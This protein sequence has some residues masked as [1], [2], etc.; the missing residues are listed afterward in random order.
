MSR[1]L[2]CKKR[3]KNSKNTFLSFLRF[4]S[5]SPARMSTIPSQQR[6]WSL[7]AGLAVSAGVYVAA[8]V[9]D[10]PSGKSVGSRVDAFRRRWLFDDRFLSQ[11]ESS[12]LSR[13][14]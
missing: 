6:A 12:F 2:D 4:H 14:L 7:L 9:R 13:S 10:V 5:F 3:K 11:V 1:G 8:Q